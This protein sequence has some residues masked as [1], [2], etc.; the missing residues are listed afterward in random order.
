MA[1][2]EGQNRHCKELI[3]KFV[4]LNGLGAEI[5]LVSGAFPRSG[6][7]LIHFKIVMGK[8]VQAKDLWDGAPAS[9]RSERS[10]FI[11]SLIQG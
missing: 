10:R 6:L 3:G 11:C 5:C 1:L 7:E 4:F 9:Q 8:I 2:P